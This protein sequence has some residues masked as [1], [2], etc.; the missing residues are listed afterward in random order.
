MRDRQ[1]FRRDR[2]RPAQPRARRARSNS[3]SQHAHPSLDLSVGTPLPPPAAQ[4]R[5]S[6]TAWPPHLRVGPAA[7]TKGCGSFPPAT[8]RTKVVRARDR[9]SVH[10]PLP[11]QRSE[12]GTAEST[13]VSSTPARRWPCWPSSRG[14]GREARI[15]RHGYEATAAGYR[16]ER[17]QSLR[18]CDPMKTGASPPDSR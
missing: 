10:R 5:P 16:G 4:P 9:A 13:M 1:M 15:R 8:T 18:G 14:C 11:D 17:L 7:W 12:E 2:S 6:A 3:Y